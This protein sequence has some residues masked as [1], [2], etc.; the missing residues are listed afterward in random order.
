MTMLRPRGYL[1]LDNAKYCDS[2]SGERYA[3]QEAEM[4][5]GSGP[6]PTGRHFAAC[7]DELVPAFIP[8][9]HKGTVRSYTGAWVIVP[10]HFNTGGSYHDRC[11]WLAW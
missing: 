5:S 4:R 11:A 1:M 6:Q 9:F 7:H 3:K 10:E 8:D 2:G